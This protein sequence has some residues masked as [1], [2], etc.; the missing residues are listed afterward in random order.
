MTADLNS[1]LSYNSSANIFKS[2]WRVRHYWRNHGYPSFDSHILKKIHWI[3]NS[4]YIYSI[5]LLNSF[6][7]INSIQAFKVSL[8]ENHGFEMTNDKCQ[9]QFTTTFISLIISLLADLFRFESIFFNYF[10]GEK[11]LKYVFRQ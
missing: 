1:S 8:W 2:S 6:L 3:I 11:M 7:S 4:N 10:S 9:F 5:N